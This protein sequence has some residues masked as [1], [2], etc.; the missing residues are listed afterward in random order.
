MPARGQKLPINYKPFYEP[1]NLNEKEQIVQVLFR[2]Q[3]EYI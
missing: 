3:Y 2:F 1:D